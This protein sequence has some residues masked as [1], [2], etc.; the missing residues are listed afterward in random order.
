[1]KIAYNEIEYKS[2][3]KYTG[4]GLKSFS[5]PHGLY[6]LEEK[7][8]TLIS[9]VIENI[10]IDII[11]NDI[12]MESNLSIDKNRSEMSKVNEETFVS[13][14]YRIYKNLF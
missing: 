3:E 2:D 7:N 5:F 13:Y 11:A 12:E 6:G 1:M 10:K 4:A 8:N 9:F 14:I